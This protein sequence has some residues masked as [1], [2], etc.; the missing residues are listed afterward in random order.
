M[1]MLQSA[2]RVIRV[3]E[4]L[5]ERKSMRLDDVALELEVH[6]SNA[7]RLLGTLRRFDWVAVDEQQGRY[8][9]GHGLIRVGEAASAG[10]RMDKAIAIA[11]R[12]RDLTGETVHISIPAGDA[13]LIV[14]TIESQNVLRVI[15]NLG[16]EDP[17]H[18]TAVGKAYLACQ[19]S[20]RLTEILDRITLK[21][22]TPTTIT[23]KKKLRAQLDDIRHDGYAINVREALDS[24]AAL[25]VALNLQG[26]RQAPI[27][28]SITGPAER[29]TE[30]TI[31]SMAAEIL[32]IIE[33]FQAL[34][35]SAESAPEPT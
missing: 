17:L 27:C 6:K 21:R 10:F 30:P 13:M 9:L 14:G 28:L 33:P 25:A 15:F 3:I 11:E 34:S 19:E 18:A 35:S 32:K 26:D 5:A 2:A 24:T 8:R 23:S 22:Y 16:T 31:R 1:E 29:F 12:L 20:G 4:L 7:L